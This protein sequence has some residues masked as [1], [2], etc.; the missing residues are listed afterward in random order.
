MDQIS[1]HPA[2]AQCE[3][4][5]NAAQGNNGAHRERQL[6]VSE[7]AEQAQPLPDA[8][9][10]KELPWTDGLHRIA[11]LGAW[12]WDLKA[13]QFHYCDIAGGHLSRS[14]GPNQVN[15]ATLIVNIDAR[16]QDDL[17]A[18]LSGPETASTIKSLEIRMVGKDLSPG[19]CLHLTGQWY[20]TP[21]EAPMMRGVVHDVTERKKAERALRKSESRLAEAQEIASLGHWE[22]E[23]E[24]NTLYW[25]HGIY[26]MFGRNREQF[27]AT[28]PNFIETIHP[29]DRDLVTG[30]V[31]DA[32]EGR[33][34]YA[35]EHRVVRPDG[36]IRWVF[37][38]ARVFRDNDGKPYRM[39]GTVLNISERKQSEEER[40]RL[41]RIVE[42]SWNE[43]YI[44]D[45]ESCKFIQ[46]NRGALANMGYTLDEMRTLTA[47]DIKPEFTEES[48]HEA[49]HPLRDGSE[50]FLI[51]ETV[52]KR[53]NGTTYPVEV[54]LQFLAGEDPPLFFA[55]IND[56]S[57]RKQAEESLREN[58][59]LL[60][61]AQEIAQIGSWQYD[62]AAA[63]L[64]Y[65]DQVYG[66][67]GVSRQDFEPTV[68][69]WLSLVHPDDR[70]DAEQNV[71]DILDDA[72]EL[73]S[74][75]RIVRPDGA[76]RYVHQINLPVT[77]G[78]GTVIGRRGTI[79]DVT[80]RRLAE[81]EIRQLNEG[82]ELRVAER[83]R[84][85]RDEIQEREQAQ[86]ALE[87]SELR[88]R[89]MRDTA[90]DAIITIDPAGAILSYNKAAQN[91]FGH[92]AD[93]VLG[94]NISLLMSSD[95]AAEHDG[96]LAAYLNND[97]P[98]IIGLNREA[99]GRRADGSHFP[100]EISVSETRTAT[101]RSFTGILRDIS[102]RKA[103][104]ET[105][106]KTIDDLRL[107]Q[108][109]LVESEKMAS[110]GGLVAGVAHEINTPIGIGVTAASHLQEA[111]AAL[112]SEFSGATLKRS[113]LEKFIT[114]AAESADIVTTN[115][116]RAATLIG[117]FKKVAVDQ[118]SED[119]RRFDLGDYIG[120]VIT[121]LGP[122]L[123]SSNHS[124]IMRCEDE[125][126]IDGDP[127]VISQIV[128]N[129]VLNTIE[130]GYAENQAGALS[131]D[132]SRAEDMIRIVYDDDGRGIDVDT[133]PHIF[134]PFF[135]TRRGSGGS[136]LGL[137]I[138]YNL[139]SQQLGGTIR[140][141]SEPG[142]GTKFIVEFSADAEERTS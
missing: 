71:R 81:N 89:V 88:L 15:F 16:N 72:V 70:R 35:M 126:I 19:R 39:V 90:A 128:T 14:D 3:P 99:V 37:E 97:Q 107:T 69:N 140:C 137:H 142:E 139:V 124:F 77:D 56:I 32:L 78:Q 125:T 58:K 68:E 44:F 91:I 130:H 64:K 48:F 45:A 26:E 105:L 13:R 76:V 141:E 109:Q 6:D 110:L 30:G 92:A 21:G 134:E 84:E 53:Q 120:E 36:E 10:W 24:S 20:E 127:G 7:N 114:T 100:V 118:S 132:I 18:F 17:A 86:A 108:G 66:I 119:H 12:R 121:S 46:A 57:A 113:D 42:D 116:S 31:N 5:A 38:R 34:P 61:E 82:L 96:Y 47:Y 11:E 22:W 87:E 133:L 79:Q 23:I 106:R 43:I 95:T 75:L 117:S 111:V 29:E 73:N 52:H 4:D 93:S 60:A 129:L 83:T 80:E 135:T 55:V 101:G 65:S 54:R 104:E 41:G 115:L 8:G 28:Y 67:L 49:L 74:E 40:N 50:K 98:T 63:I 85:L 112:Q 1:G 122:R 102:E 123:R 94:A 59:E 33:A 136:G 25:S 131:L 103:N 27:E 2:K 51:F 62:N 9:P 138:V